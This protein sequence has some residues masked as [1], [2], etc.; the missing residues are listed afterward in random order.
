MAPLHGGR[1]DEREPHTEEEEVSLLDYWRV[2]SKFW[3]LILTL[4]GTSVLTAVVWSLMMPKIY[5]STATILAPKESGGAGAGFSALL[6]SSGAAQ[7]LPQ[8]GSNRDVFVAI[9]KSRTMAQDVVERF[10]LKEYFRTQSIPQAVGAVQGMAKIALSREGTISVAVEA[11]DPQLAADIANFYVS[12][13][14]RLFAKLGT[15][16][17]G[18][19]RAF[20]VDRLLQTEKALR[21][22]EETLR[23]YQERNRTIVL[24]D[25]SRVAIDAAALLKG[26]IIASE[27]QLEVMKNFATENNP[28]V[29][30]LK[31]QITEMK[32]QLAQM[33]YGGAMELPGNPGGVEPDF[34]VPF[35]RVPQVGLELAR[36]TRDVKVQETVFTLL[37]QQLEQ[38]KIAEAR[39]TP[40]VQ[41]LDRAV[42]AERKSKP[43]IRLNVMLAGV[44]SLFAGVFLAFCLEYVEKMRGPRPSPS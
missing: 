43:K 21:Q 15:S 31:K 39:D 6:A 16:E 38:A 35:S 5:E 24:Q 29:I 11:T 18:R 36:L 25:Q 22:A 44:V 34:S 19:N 3:K 37:K 27:V 9:L 33:Q 7:F 17:A 1:M 20:I 30:Q 13:L 32:R 12:N 40:T 8:I 14:D 26:E 42:P 10:N 23:R 28:Q 41:V 4:A 2:I